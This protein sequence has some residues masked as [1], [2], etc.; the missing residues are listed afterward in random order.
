[1]KIN[2]NQ[3]NPII[4]EQNIFIWVVYYAKQKENIN[5]SRTKELSA[6]VTLL[7]LAFQFNNLKIDKNWNG[8]S[9]THQHKQTSNEH[10]QN[11]LT[12]QKL[13]VVDLND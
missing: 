13:D 2:E 4:V 3:V 1:M 11:S 5:V 6:E 12:K 8:K 9:Q 10:Q 7:F